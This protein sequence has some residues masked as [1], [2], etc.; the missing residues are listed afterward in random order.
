MPP[1]IPPSSELSVDPEPSVCP[2]LSACL[3]FP[4]THPPSLAS[5]TH[6]CLSH[7]TQV[8]SPW[9]CQFPSTS[10]LE[11]PSSPPP[12][13]ESWTPPW[14]S[15]PAAPPQLLVSSSPPSAHQLHWAL[16]P[17]APPWS[18]VDPPKSILCQSQLLN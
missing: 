2:D 10:W 12:A 3:A 7:A 14:P 9:V 13:S 1:L 6:P 4:Q 11:D 15:D 17:L 8:G 5:S 16:V 18:V